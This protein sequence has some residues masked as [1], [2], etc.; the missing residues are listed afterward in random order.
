MGATVTVRDNDGRVFFECPPD[1]K[2]RAYEYAEKMER[3]GIDVSL[4]CPSL[5]ESLASSL[6]ADEAALLKL[7]DELR[8][9]IDSHPDEHT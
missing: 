2:H 5:P 9:E 4:S 8:R 7:K 6:G 3:M 1:E